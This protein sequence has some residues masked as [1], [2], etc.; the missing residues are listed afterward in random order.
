MTA[1]MVF[2]DY[3]ECRECPFGEICVHPGL[4]SRVYGEVNPEHDTCVFF[5]GQAPGVREDAEGKVWIGESGKRLATLVK[6]SNLGDHVA[7]VMGNAFRCLPPLGKTGF[8]TN[9]KKCF[10]H[11]VED[12]EVIAGL[13]G[14]V[15]V[16]ALGAPAAYAFTRGS[17]GNAL[18]SQGQ[19]LNSLP[20]SPVLF[21][22]YH[23]AILLPGRKPQLIHAMSL[24]FTL[25]FKFIMT[26]EIPHLV[27]DLEPIVGG[28]PPDE[29]Y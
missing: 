18:G 22:S 26:G 2:K 9:V 11:I 12:L 16:V 7:V 8:N 19:V 21:A 5:V 10:P 24:H 13:Y 6:G 23:P 17:L 15:I 25:L 3:P 20:G 27:D 1:V 29:L 28:D 14:R 4:A